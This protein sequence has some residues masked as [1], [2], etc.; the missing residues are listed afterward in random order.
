M[1]KTFLSIFFTKKNVKKW[2]SHQDPW[3]VRLDFILLTNYDLFY[4]QEIRR[5][6]VSLYLWP[7]LR[8]YPSCYC[9]YRRTVSSRRKWPIKFWK[10]R[11]LPMHYWWVIV[12]VKVFQTH[13]SWCVEI[14]YHATFT[15]PY[16]W[17][18]KWYVMRRKSA[19][20]WALFFPQ[21]IKFAPISSPTIQYFEEGSSD[22]SHLWYTY[23]K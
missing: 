18:S 3:I 21:C 1:D 14:A 16:C 22:K 12:S 5:S 7:S 6:S 19:H 2:R 13:L 8:H 11:Y 23:F 17:Y 10:S 9:A 4:F 15:L 20:I